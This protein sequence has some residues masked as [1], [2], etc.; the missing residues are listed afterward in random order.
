MENAVSVVTGAN[1]GVGRA[2]AAALARAGHHIVM[3]CRSRAR[4]EA[5]QRDIQQEAS[6]AV[7]L[8]VADLSVQAEVRRV[9]GELLDAYPRIDVLINCAGAQ[10]SRRSLTADGIER[11]FALN[12]LAY[13]LLTQLLLERLQASAPAR[14]VNVASAAANVGRLDAGNLQGERFYWGFGAYARSK[15]ANIVY[16]RSL[17]ERL[18][19]SLVTVNCL[20]PGTVRTNITRGNSGLVKLFFNKFGVSAEQGADTVIWLASAP[21]LEAVSGRFYIDRKERPLP[22]RAR[23]RQLAHDLWSECERLTGHPVGKL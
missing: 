8:H 22:T 21:D 20:H 2:T 15:L 7:D 3:V 13:F 9:A 19:P 11:T 6:G 16:T 18:D 4:G 12:H 14:I 10:F 5:A 23:D 1:S 17:A